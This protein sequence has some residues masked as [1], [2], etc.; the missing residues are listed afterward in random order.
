[1][2]L[3]Q[4]LAHFPP[5]DFAM[6]YG[7]GV[8]KQSG[9]DSSS[10]M[11]DLVLAVEDPVAWHAEQ[12]ARH[13]EHYSGLKVFGPKAIAYIQEELG[14]GV[15]YNTLAQIP[16]TN[17]LMKYGVVRTSTLCNELTGWSNLYLSGRMHK[18]VN[19][20]ASVP[21]VDAASSTNLSHALHLALL[22]LPETFTEEELFMKIAGISYW[23]DFR[24]TFGENPKKVRNIVH[25]NLEGFQTVYAKKLQTSPY[26]QKG[27]TSWTMD[28]TP[29]AREA[30]LASLPENVTSRMKPKHKA[31]TIA[32]LNGKKVKQAVSSI[33]RT[34]S[35]TQSI[36]GILT[37]G[38]V[39]TV[40]YIW[41]KLS[42][43]YLR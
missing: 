42:R 21:S 9:H 29:L 5:V 39:K 6:G 16:G 3:A 13:P 24:M 22:G 37:A 26:L 25:G 27:P 17:Q 32:S 35:R 31:L 36:K 33:V 10:S 15:Y 12:V 7:S 2:S 28:T 18:P 38:G 41:Q 19:I 8:F 40:Q 43:T 20:L 11:V 14:A 30:M 23:G 4:L 1:M 34:S